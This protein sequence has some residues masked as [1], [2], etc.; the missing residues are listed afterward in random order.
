DLIPPPA[1]TSTDKPLP[2][3]N[4]ASASWRQAL[5]T[6]PIDANSLGSKYTGEFGATYLPIFLI[7]LQQTFL[8]FVAQC[9]GM[10]KLKFL[11]SE[12]KNWGSQCRTLTKK[13][14]DSKSENTRLTK[15]TKKVKKNLEA[16]LAVA[17]N[18]AKDKTKE[19]EKL[20]GELAAA[21]MTLDG[22]RPRPKND[23]M[24]LA[25]VPFSELRWKIWIWT[26]VS[27]KNQ[28]R[29]FLLSAR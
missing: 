3:A 14:H 29:K 18:E 28:R 10:G 5:E 4:Q 7:R 6:L 8:S 9:H 23:A 11:E 25:S 1:F 16:K 19:C 27:R 2:N 26:Q 22:K 17:E 20:K 12:V 13:W 24:L 21:K 15:D